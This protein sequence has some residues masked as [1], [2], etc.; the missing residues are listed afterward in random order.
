MNETNENVRER[1]RA[2]FICN[3]RYMLIDFVYLTT[4]IV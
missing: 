4:P 3:V 1:A 2:H